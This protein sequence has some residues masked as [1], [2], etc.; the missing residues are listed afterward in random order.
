MPE[1]Y[2]ANSSE[3]SFGKGGNEMGSAPTF[4]TE[5]GREKAA[6]DGA[7]PSKQT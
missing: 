6:P 2:L 5:E 7:A 1:I 3:T 4:T